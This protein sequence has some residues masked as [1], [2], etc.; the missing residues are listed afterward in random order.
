MFIT[1]AATNMVASELAK[2]N[3]SSAERITSEALFLALCSGSM[4]AVLVFT[5]G[6]PLL[7][8]IAGHA[9]A[10]VVPSA[11]RYAS[12]RAIG[13]PFVVMAS[14]ARA[15]AL[16]KKDTLGPLLSVAIAFVLNAFGTATLIKYTNLGIMG[17]AIGT[18]CADVIAT[19]FLLRRIQWLRRK[20]YNLMEPT[21]IAVASTNTTTASPILTTKSIN[22]QIQK[23]TSIPPLFVI[24]TGDNFRRFL[25]YAAP[26]FFTLLGKT[27]VY[28]GIALS[29]GRQGSVSLAAHQVLLGCFFFFCPIGDSVGM[30]SQVFLPGI[31]N[32]EQRTGKP[33]RGAKRL[34]FS[35]GVTAGAIAAAFAGLLPSR[36]AG[37]FTKDAL[38]KAA[39]QRTSPILAFSVS[40]HAIAITCEG[41]LLAQKDLGFLST[42]YIVTTFAAIGLMISP[43]RPTT[44]GQSWGILASFQGIRALQFMFRNLLITRRKE[45]QYNK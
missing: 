11:L 45:R 44:L 7:M 34:M 3:N 21:T 13:Q 16:V 17:A 5:A 33:E 27:V 22:N 10:T 18:L 42:S 6:R 36:G 31:L 29:V 14:V 1:T 2:G 28:N 20:E 24:P 41:M 26:I 38:V 43:L 25:R 32:K 19:T 30:T 15:S 40:M 35:V 37:L 8:Q 4:L 12:I 23:S 39:L 9:S